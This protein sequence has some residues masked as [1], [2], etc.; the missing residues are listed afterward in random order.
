MTGPAITLAALEPTVD[1]DMSAALCRDQDPELWFPCGTTGTAKVQAAQ[2]KAICVRCPVLAACRARR[3]R[4]GATDGVWAGRW[5]NAGREVG[6]P[7]PKVCGC[8]QPL[9]KPKA[10]KRCATCRTM[11][12][13]RTRIADLHQVGLNPQQIADQLGIR[14]RAVVDDLRHLRKTA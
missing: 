13:R 10:S 12:P 1:E 14:R 5:F 7:R 6:K 2:A 8:G 11:T 4:L 3:E 9:D